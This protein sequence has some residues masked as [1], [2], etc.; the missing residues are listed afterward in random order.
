MSDPK[1]PVD[2]AAEKDNQ[3][4]PPGLKD[5]QLDELADS[6]LDEVSGGVTTGGGPS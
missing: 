6:V 1:S 2:P 4:N 3:A 5:S